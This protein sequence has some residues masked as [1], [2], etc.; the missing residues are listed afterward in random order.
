MKTTNKILIALTITFVAAIYACNNTHV[1][2]E[3]HTPIVYVDTTS[4]KQPVWMEEDE[5]FSLTAVA[6]ST[7]DATL[8]FLLLDGDSIIM[9][10]Q[11]GQFV[12][13][14]QREEGY[15]LQVKAQWPDTVLFSLP[16]SVTGFVHLEK[17]N[18]L[19]KEELQS[20]ICSCDPEI[21]SG[22]HKALAQ[23]LNVVVEDSQHEPISTLSQVIQYIKL[24]RWKG[25]IVKNV[26]Y[27]STGHLTS[28]TI[29]PVGE[30]MTP[31]T[32]QPEPEPDDLLEGW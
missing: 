23:P 17:I 20:L 19:S 8:T 24:K 29:T 4:G 11:T 32:P 3:K 18:P 21:S 2:S 22:K 16:I 9:T 12:G 26:G 31:P 28:I 27:D 7:G 13:I 5:S 30:Q 1:S 25:V 14:P 15:D 10:S 6:D